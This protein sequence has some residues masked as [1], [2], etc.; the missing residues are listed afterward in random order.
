MVGQRL[1]RDAGLPA[2]SLWSLCLHQAAAVAARGSRR[3]IVVLDG[4]KRMRETACGKLR[5][6]AG[7]RAARLGGVAGDGVGDLGQD[8]G[9]V[10][11]AEPFGHPHDLVGGVGGQ[12]AGDLGEFGVRDGPHLLIDR[13][14][15]T[16]AGDLPDC[17]GTSGGMQAGDDCGRAAHGQQRAFGVCSRRS[18][19]RGGRR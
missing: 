6:A 8:I 15:F 9:V 7:G 18:Q 1:A 5:R 16:V 2:G 14:Q 13:G 19:G 11:K 3:F 10:G 4:H 17:L 12:D